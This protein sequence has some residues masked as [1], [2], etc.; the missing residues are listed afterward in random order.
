AE[1]EQHAGLPAALDRDLEFEEKVWCALRRRHRDAREQQAENPG[2]RKRQ[3]R[4][5]THVRLEG[6]HPKCSS[7]ADQTKNTRHRDTW[8]NQAIER[9]SQREEGERIMGRTPSLVTSAATLRS[10]TQPHES[11]L[12]RFARCR[13]R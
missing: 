4:R 6:L 12:A 2:E 7:S 9:S 5:G 11:R 1:I 8:T 10:K 13:A 3:V